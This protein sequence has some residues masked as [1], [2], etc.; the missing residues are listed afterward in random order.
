MR[1]K[2]TFLII[3]IA[4]F[5]PLTAVRAA[6]IGFVPSSGVWFSS[7]PVF[8]NLATK[9][10]TVV[11][12]NQYQRLTAV[13]AFFDNDSE[14]A[15][16][17]LDIG[18]E[19]AHQ[20]SGIWKPLYG[21]HVVVAKFVSA[22]GTDV[23]GSAHQLTT[24]EINAIAAPIS[25]TI[26]VDND[27]DGDGLGDHDEISTYHTSPLVA[28]TDGDGLSDGA[29]V[30]KYHTDPLKADTDGD[31]MNDG[32]E[33][34]VG[35][36]PLVPDA[37]PPPPPPPVAPILPTQNS[38]TNDATNNTASKKETKTSP[39]PTKTTIQKIDDSKTAAALK[40]KTENAETVKP[41]P[42]IS[43]NKNSTSTITAATPEKA[44]A[45]SAEQPALSKTAANF[46]NEINWIKVLG[47]V[48]GLLAVAA[49]VSGGLA[50]RE[51]NRY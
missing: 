47:I 3:L 34:K 49:A 43:D 7:D 31:G 36:N 28:D 46:A 24:D 23:S 5:F 10:F 21:Q 11:V 50:M 51:R 15:R 29:E 9:V 12:N 33:I 18:M 45:L 17:N 6:G 19:E 27:S 16:T 13:I 22:V 32:D 42:N 1:F 26:F 20:I 14:F 30:K 8:S 38:N 2:M 40:T 4:L 39:A 37:P 41:A 35:R 44:A 25:R 48:A